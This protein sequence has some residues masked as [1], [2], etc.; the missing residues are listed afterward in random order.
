MERLV[1]ISE[2]IVWRLMRLQTAR[3]AERPLA[4]S[5]ARGEVQT[6]R[7][8]SGGPPCKGAAILPGSAARLAGPLKSVTS[9]QRVATP[10][11]AQTDGGVD[12]ILGVRGIGEEK[13]SFARL[14]AGGVGS[15]RTIAS[16]DG[17]CPV[18]AMAPR[19]MFASGA[20]FVPA[21]ARGTP[22]EAQRRR[23]SSRFPR[24]TNFPAVPHDGIKFVIRRRVP[25]AT[26]A[27]GPLRTWLP[28]F[29]GRLFPPSWS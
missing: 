20:T 3:C 16:R 26:P 27:N 18:Q 19:Q 22:R 15:L 12:A 24:C 13:S 14:C 6:D 2:G 25:Q 1:P 5:D 8:E 21:R 11:R 29:R 10:P 23:N 17:F 9:A 7:R 28:A 4:R